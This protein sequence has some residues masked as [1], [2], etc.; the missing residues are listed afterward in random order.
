[1][2]VFGGYGCDIHHTPLTCAIALSETDRRPDFAEKVAIMTSEYP[3]L[4]CK[5]TERFISFAPLQMAGV[6]RTSHAFEV[7]CKLHSCDDM[8]VFRYIL[9]TPAVVKEKYDAF[10]GTW[11]QEAQPVR[12]LV[13]EY[14][15]HQNFLKY[16]L[17]HLKD[18]IND[19]DK[20]EFTPLHEL[21]ALVCRMRPVTISATELLRNGTDSNLPNANGDTPLHVLCYK[22]SFSTAEEQLLCVLLASKADT[23]IT[24]IEELTPLGHRRVQ[25]PG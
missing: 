3:R 9:G 15:E 16:A 23:G 2:L 4:L 12:R 11:E 7:L 13:S 8:S 25:P 5:P 1:M 24:N 18:H 14:L 6:I 19:Q 21:C 20:D 10:F 22:Y 17:P